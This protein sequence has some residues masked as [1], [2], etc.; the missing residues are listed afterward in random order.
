METGWII[1]EVRAESGSAVLGLS[2]KESQHCE[3]GGKPV[4]ESGKGQKEGIYSVEF[5]DL[6]SMDCI[7][8]CGECW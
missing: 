7:W 1:L 4:E 8:Q 6:R 5:Q 3:A 2:C